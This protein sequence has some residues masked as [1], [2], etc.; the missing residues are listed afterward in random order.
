MQVNCASRS[1]SADTVPQIVPTPRVVPPI[2]RIKLVPNDYPGINL[3]HQINTTRINPMTI[4]SPRLNHTLQTNTV[5]QINPMIHVFPQISHVPQIDPVMNANSRIDHTPQVSPVTN[6][7][8]STDPV[9]TNPV[10]QIDSMTTIAP[11]IVSRVSHAPM[12]SDTPQINPISQTKSSIN[13]AFHTK[14]IDGKPNKNIKFIGISPPHIGSEISQN[15]EKIDISTISVGS[16]DQFVRI[17]M[18]DPIRMKKFIISFIEKPMRDMVY[19]QGRKETKSE[20]FISKDGVTLF[21]GQA[22]Y[23][24]FLESI[25]PGLAQQYQRSD[26]SILKIFNRILQEEFLFTRFPNKPRIGGRQ[27]VAFVWPPRTIAGP[28]ILSDQQWNMVIV[29]FKNV[30]ATQFGF[31]DVSVKCC[32]GEIA[33]RW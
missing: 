5:A 20:M 24:H 7:I 1:I 25:Q 21:S 30:L 8:L 33:K 3:T 22:L 15:M 18:S 14:P 2:L 16:T 19:I 10:P 11:Q 32:I 12:P 9:L 4:T 13:I 17:S 27:A 23:D 28:P 29:T 31:N 6:P 26:V